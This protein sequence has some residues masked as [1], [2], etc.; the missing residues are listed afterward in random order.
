MA[1]G[2]VALMRARTC[3]VNEYLIWEVVKRAKSEGFK[4]LDLGESDAASL[5][6][7]KRSL[8]RY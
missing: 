5:L 4:K 3:S 8:I 6:D 7:T 1:I 2:S